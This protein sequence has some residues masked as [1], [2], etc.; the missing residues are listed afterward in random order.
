MKRRILAFLGVLLTVFMGTAVLNPTEVVALGG[1]DCGAG[2]PLGFRAWYAG[3]CDGNEKDSEI[4]KPDNQ[5]ESELVQFI[6]TIILNVLFDLL[7][8][9]GYLALGFVVYGGFLYIM[10]QGDPVKLA[11]GKRTLT[12]AIIGTVIALVASIAVNTIR[13]ILGINSNDLWAQQEF[14]KDNISGAFAW[15]Y[16]VAGIVAVIFIIKGALDYL[17][18]SGDPAKTRKAT[19]SIIYAVVGLVIVLLAALITTF[20]INSTGGALQQ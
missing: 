1:G 14:T 2:T 20:V 16:S 18:S 10:S 6:W 17:L 15:A 12:A 9:V 13:V 4:Q 19:Q 3:L 7:V 5:D 8:A 11:K